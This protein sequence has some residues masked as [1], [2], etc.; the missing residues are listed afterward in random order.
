MRYF[1]GTLS[2]L[3]LFVAGNALGVDFP[4]VQ[5]PPAPE[6]TAEL[7]YVPFPEPQ[8]SENSF[9][10]AT[11]FPKTFEDL[12]FSSRLAILREN[13]LPY[14]IEY[15]E[16]GVCVKNCAYHGITIVEDMQAV[17]EATEE[18]ADLIAA[19]EEEEEEP[20]TPETPPAQTPGWGV[21]GG[22]GAIT[23]SN[24][25]NN[26]LSTKLPLRYPVDMT[27]FRYRITSDFGFRPKSQNGARFHPAVDIGCPSG[28]PVYATADG[29]VV[30][31]A[32]ETSRGGAG[33]YVSIKHDNG[34]ITQYLHLSSILVK[35]GDSVRACQQ[36][37]L[38][39]NSGTGVD[40][41][42]YAAHLDYRIRFD[43]DRNKY[44]DILC[45]CKVSTRVGNGQ[46]SD[47]P[48]N[49]TC[50]HSLFN[51]PYKFTKYNPDNDINKR[52]VWRVTNG[53][54][55][56]KKTDLLPDEVAP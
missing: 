34:L 36:I 32:N 6:N 1:W 40:G 41:N 2:L 9:L 31:V 35:H 37:A 14:M 26:G 27:G 17:D 46:S 55:M 15:D 47:N 22:G 19:A 24:W 45:P 20:E 38:S 53:H 43:S 3:A 52:S 54:C 16:N 30:T 39:G 10:K 23:S 5:M 18:I 4:A 42:G 25:C 56:T 13:Y 49:I 29:V 33:K 51:L 44:V 11:Q 28:T 8:H 7:D 21:N 50:A 12:S 48:V